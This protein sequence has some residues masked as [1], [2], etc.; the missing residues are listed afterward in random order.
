MK[1]TRVGMRITATVERRNPYSTFRYA[2]LAV[3]DGKRTGGKGMNEK[4]I[5]WI[6]ERWGWTQA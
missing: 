5:S 4:M 6:D 3:E 1:A 2:S